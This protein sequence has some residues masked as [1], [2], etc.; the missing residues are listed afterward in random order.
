MFIAYAKVKFM[1]KKAQKMGERNREYIVVR[2]L[3][4]LT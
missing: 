2:S 1:G 3:K 4:D